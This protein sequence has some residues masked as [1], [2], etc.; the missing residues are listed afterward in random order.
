MSE[1]DGIR[2]VQIKLDMGIPEEKALYEQYM[3]ISRQKR[4]SWL[5]AHIVRSWLYM[6]QL[7]EIA[8][9]RVLAGHKPLPD[10]LVERLLKMRYGVQQAQE[11]QAALDAAQSSDPGEGE[12]QDQPADKGV[13][14]GDEARST[15]GTLFGGVR[16]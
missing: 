5:V 7:A 15:L 4:G 6:S 11:I 8:G 12:K 13:A 2:R 1:Q 14:T 16:F 9:L 10:D 3:A